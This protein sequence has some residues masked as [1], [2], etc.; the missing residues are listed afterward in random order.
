MKVNI[1]LMQRMRRDFPLPLTLALMAF[2]LIM[3]WGHAANPQP[4]DTLGDVL[5][6]AFGGCI[7]SEE[8]DLHQIISWMMAF[9]PSGIAVSM[10]LFSRLS[11]LSTMEGYRYGH[12]LRWYGSLMAQMAGIAALVALLQIGCVLLVAFLGGYRGFS[13]W[14]NDVDGFL[15]RNELLP[16]LTPLLFLLYDE[17]IVLFAVAV[18]LLARKMTWFYVAFLLPSIVGAMTFSNPYKHSMFHLVSFGMAYRMSVEGSP[19][20]PP[21]LACGGLLAALALILLLGGVYCLLVS[22]F[23]RKA[24]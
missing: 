13:V 2:S 3:A 14:V 15:V 24:E 12:V 21:A 6:F 22:P 19:G 16:C 11:G 9:V 23:D 1:T 17:V 4:G 18:Y 7:W 8:R 5:I 20:I 10:A